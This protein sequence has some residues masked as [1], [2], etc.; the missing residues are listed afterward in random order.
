MRI[1]DMLGTL[2]PQTGEKMDLESKK[3]SLKRST[4]KAC[5]LGSLGLVSGSCQGTCR[6]EGTRLELFPPCSGVKTGSLVG[7]LYFHRLPVETGFEDS[8]PGVC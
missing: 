3:E 5:G 1:F 2:T 6:G 4:C 7:Q 8:W